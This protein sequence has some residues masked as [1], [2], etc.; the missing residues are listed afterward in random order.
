MDHQCKKC[1]S[2]K[3]ESGFYYRKGAPDTSWCKECYRQWHLNGRAGGVITKSCEFCSKDFE[4]SSRAGQRK[5]FCSR[6]CKTD[7]R[8]EADKVERRASKPERQCIHCTAA[9]GPEMRIDAIFCSERCQT[10]A[11]NLVKKINRRSALHGIPPLETRFIDRAFI[12][13]RDKGICQICGDPVDLAA[14]HPDPFYAS[15]D[16]KVPMSRQGGH[17]IDNL[18]L[19]HLHCNISKRNN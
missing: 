3:D 5:R 18:Q 13:T 2:I 4:C 14:E 8:R 7:A 17:E 19:A 15:I 1:K 16:H 12:I 10:A 9:I 11:N 6:E